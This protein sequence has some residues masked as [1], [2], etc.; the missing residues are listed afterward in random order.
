MDLRGIWGIQVGGLVLKLPYFVGAT[1]AAQYFPG[2]TYWP[3]L[4]YDV[5]FAFVILSNLVK[6]ADT[7]GFLKPSTEK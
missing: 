5:A 1:L 2:D 3:L 6:S 4:A 7:A